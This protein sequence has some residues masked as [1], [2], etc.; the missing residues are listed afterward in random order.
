[1]IE[2]AMSHS[3]KLEGSLEYGVNVT[4]VTFRPLQ[5][6]FPLINMNRFGYVEKA[7]H[8]SLIREIPPRLGR[9]GEE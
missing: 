7:T 9:P 6:D 5:P 3:T 4:S 8:M 2:N 1:M